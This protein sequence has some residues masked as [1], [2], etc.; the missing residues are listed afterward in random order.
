MRK[1]EEESTGQRLLS[2]WIKIRFITVV[3]FLKL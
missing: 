3:I 2:H 1:K